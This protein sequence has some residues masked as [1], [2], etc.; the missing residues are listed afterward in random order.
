MRESVLYCH[1][2]AEKGKHKYAH[3]YSHPDIVNFCGVEKDEIVKVSVSEYRGKKE[4]YWGWW[5]C[6]KKN[7]YHVYPIKGMVEMCSPDGFKT[8]IKK[9]EG[10]LCA[11]KIKVIK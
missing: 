6:E 7:F 9:G 2:K 1:N 8:A 3:F 11:V 5:D 10:K 4:S